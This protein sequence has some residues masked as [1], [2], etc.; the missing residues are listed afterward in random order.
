MNSSHVRYRLVSFNNQ[1]ADR[2]ERVL[3]VA[4]HHR[5]DHSVVLTAGGRH[6]AVH[7]SELMNPHT[8]IL[9]LQGV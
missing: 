2:Y 3:L 1:D 9:T 7:D 6:I 5:D 8:R 4:R